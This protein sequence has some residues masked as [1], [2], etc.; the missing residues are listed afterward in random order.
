LG[1]INFDPTKGGGVNMLG[2]PMTRLQ[3]LQFDGSANVLFGAVT[4]L[5]YGEGA[6]VLTVNPLSSP[7]QPLLAGQ[8]L[9]V[10]GNV[11]SVVPST[12]FGSGITELLGERIN[13]SNSAL[14]TNMAITLSPALAGGILKITNTTNT[15]AI[16]TDAGGGTKLSVTSN[17]STKFNNIYMETAD[18]SGVSKLAMYD[19]VTGTNAA[20]TFNA[21]NKYLTTSCDKTVALSA[22]GGNHE[23]LM[24]D[25]GNVI[26]V[27]SNGDPIILQR[28]NAGG[29][30]N[31][32]QLTVMDDGI[33]QIGDVDVSSNPGIKFQ[34]FSTN[35]FLTPYTQIAMDISDTL[36][37]SGSS[38]GIST[39]Q[40]DIPLRDAVYST[41]IATQ[42]LTSQGPLLPP[43]WAA[44]GGGGGGGGALLASKVYYY[45][46]AD[47]TVTINTATFS[48]IPT[49]SP[50]RIRIYSQAGGGGGGGGAGL[51]AGN[52]FGGIMSGGGGGGG[53]AG[54]TQ[55][56]FFDISY[57][58]TFT[59]N[60]GDGGNGG[61]GGNIV[62]GPS[63][64]DGIVG[65]NNTIQTTIGGK[66]FS[67][68]TNGGAGGVAGSSGVGGNGD[69]PGE[70]APAN[71][72]GPGTDV[73]PGGA[74]GGL[75]G[76]EAGAGDGSISLSER[77][78]GRGIILPITKLSGAGGGGGGGGAGSAGENGGI[79]AS[80][81][82]QFDI[83][84]L[85]P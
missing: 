35:P 16:G 54:F 68:T 33:I 50:V 13:I 5:N 79:G 55:D 34:Q 12:F 78:A 70:M 77:N 84:S 42:V 72:T 49:S 64:T 37:I 81:F 22:K 2:A 15:P 80:G 32:T 31:K 47:Q 56:Y 19:G 6:K 57:G 26:I 66:I 82:I 28:N 74:G 14:S 67:Y 61:S 83:Y 65:D 60:V 4:G 63:A 62:I 48:G 39:A 69:P 59:I 52:P 30:I 10:N 18:I 76:G 44:G 7:P 3:E 85:L 20:V 27:T 40:I 9:T 45:T 41:G 43:I 53:G 8:G 38:G 1:V 25:S 23:I 36:V 17:G 24:S 21:S 58:E 71:V 51:G 29:T 75:F 46:G 73:T 11:Q